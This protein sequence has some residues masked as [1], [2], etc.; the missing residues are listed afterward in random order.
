MPKKPDIND[1]DKHAFREA[2]RHVKPLA[3]SKV[4]VISRSPPPRKKYPVQTETSLLNNTLDQFSNYETLAPVSSHDLLN[5]AKPGIQDKALRKLRA[6]QYNVDAV[7]DL[8][9]MT[10]EDARQSLSRFLGHCQQKGFN[11]VLMIHGKGRS[12]SKPILKNKLNHWLRQTEQVLAFCSATARNG[13]SGAL[14]VLLRKESD[15]CRKKM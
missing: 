10:V 2:M 15:L 4:T 8:H 12:V 9:G 1:S 5:F 14:Y 3:H 11:H 13:S 7:L 6:G